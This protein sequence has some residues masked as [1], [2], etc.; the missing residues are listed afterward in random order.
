[1]Y[2]RHV[3]WEIVLLVWIVGIQIAVLAVSEFAHRLTQRARRAASSSGPP[4]QVIPLVPR[5]RPAGQMRATAGSPARAASMRQ[6]Y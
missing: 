5:T 2:L 1:L 4:A 3:V 6:R